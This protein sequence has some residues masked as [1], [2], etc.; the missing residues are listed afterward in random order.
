MTREVVNHPGRF[1]EVGPNLRL[2]EVVLGDGERR[3]RYVLC[4]NP[5]EEKRQQEHRKRVIRDLEAELETVR[6]QPDS[7]HTKRM[8]QLMASS[9]YGRFLIDVPGSGLM[10]NR[11]A[12]EEAKKYDGKWVVTSNDDTLRAEDLALGYKQ[13]MRVEESWRTLKSGLGLRPV[14]HWRPWRIQAHVTIAGLALLLERVIEIRGQD[15][16]RNLRAQLKTIKVVAYERGGTHV[17]QTTEVRP[18]VAALLRKLR[19]APPPTLHT[20]EAAEG[21]K[22]RKS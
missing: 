3:R 9:R 22:A 20:V 11:T 13:L 12:I 6:S 19:V 5:Q 7:T 2:K 4:H 8:C 15:T 10:V 17:R 18:S 16:W 1:K 21:G 14:Y